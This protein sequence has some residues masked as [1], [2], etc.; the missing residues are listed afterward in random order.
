MQILEGLKLPRKLIVSWQMQRDML[1]QIYRKIIQDGFSPDFVA[2]IARGGLTIG[3]CFSDWFGVPI[4]VVVAESY[5][6][7]KRE[8]EIHF[9]RH[10]SY[11]SETVEGQVLLVDDLTD[12]GQTITK[13]KGYLRGKF[14]GITGFKTACLLHK[15]TSTIEP[16][17]YA[18]LVKVRG[19]DTTPWVEFPQERAPEVRT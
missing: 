6:N 9:S 14:P 18:K 15:E 11:T 19:D 17:Y 8:E 4:V 1:E 16:D 12:S 13:T 10:C 3:H 5:H 2:A 7:N